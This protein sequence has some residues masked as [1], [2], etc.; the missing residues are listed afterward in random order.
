MPRTSCLRSRYSDA[1]DALSMGCCGNVDKSDYGVMSVAMR[2]L[3][4]PLKALARTSSQ[5][6][7]YRN[8]LVDVVHAPLKD[9][10]AHS[11]LDRFLVLPTRLPVDQ[12]QMTDEEITG[13]QFAIAGSA[14]IVVCSA[15]KR[16]AS[17]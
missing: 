11:E 17:V 8:I 16:Q 3:N 4:G 12:F 13:I 6:A 1:I 7:Q 14:K 9:C 15:D 5:G 2:V 10:F